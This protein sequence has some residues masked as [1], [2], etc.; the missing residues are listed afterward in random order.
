V[1]TGRLHPLPESALADFHAA[2]VLHAT[3]ACR[4][5]RIPRPL[6]RLPSHPHLVLYDFQPWMNL[7]QY[8]DFWRTSDPLRHAAQRT[9]RALAGLHRRRA[10][11]RDAP[12]D[13]IETRLARMITQAECVPGPLPW[14]WDFAHRLARTVETIRRQNPPRSLR[15][16]TTIHAAFGWDCIHYGVDKHFYLQ[17]FE[18]CRRGDPGLD[19]GGFAADLLC[20]TLTRH[21]LETYRLCRDEFLAS[22]N[23]RAEYPLG[24]EEL[25]LYIT[26]ALAR[27]FQAASPRSLPAAWRLLEALDAVCRCA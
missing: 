2:S 23:A 11:L 14:R 16:L 25:N 7:W 5:L 20:F 6:A 3:A 9:G 17:R 26:W 4:H 13:S 19:L 10:L 8:L 1:L 12:A 27:R 21:N 18:H 24:A 22:Y 15:P